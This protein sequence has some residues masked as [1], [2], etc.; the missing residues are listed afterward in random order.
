MGQKELL[1][2]LVLQNNVVL[3][4]LKLQHLLNIKG[5]ILYIF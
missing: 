1:I 4:S 3:V 5:F 2:V